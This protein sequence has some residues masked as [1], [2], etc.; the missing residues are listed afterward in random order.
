MALVMMIFVI[1]FAIP[2]IDN[3]IGIANIF[4]R[5]KKWIRRKEES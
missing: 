3:W 1:L 2:I 5:I 4:K